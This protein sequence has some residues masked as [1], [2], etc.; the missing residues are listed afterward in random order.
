MAH[1]GVIRHPRFSRLERKHRLNHS[2][3]D[4]I[5]RDFLDTR[6]AQSD[7]GQWLGKRQTPIP[8][9]QSAGATVIA[10]AGDV[11]QPTLPN[12]AT[13]PTTAADT[14][15]PTTDVSTDATTTASTTTTDAQSTTSVL[16]TQTPTTTTTTSEPTSTTATSE[17]ST[18][19]ASTT[20]SSTSATTS[21]P[22]STNTLTS[23][24]PLP[25]TE[26][27]Q[28]SDA[29][30]STT[31]STTLSSSETST[32][33]PTTAT[34]IPT[35]ASETTSP[36]S[37][38]TSD[39]P[40]TTTYFGGDGWSGGG[41][42]SWTGAATGTAT[43]GIEQAP[44]ATGAASS[45]SGSSLDSETKGKIAG[46][47]VGGVAGLAM[48]IILAL[49]F[50]RRRRAALQQPRGLPSHDVAG[51]AAANEPPRTA[52]M[53]S[54]RSS[55]D[56]LFAASYFAPAFMKRW[57]Q[58][59]QTTRS[60]STLS[61]NPSERGFQKIAGRKIPSVLQ[62]G[63]DGY[64]DGSFGQ[65]SPTASE[66]SGGFPSSPPAP[67]RTSLSQPPPSH[68][69][70]MPLDTSYTREEEEAVIY[71]PSPARTPIAGSSNVS[72]STEPGISH[73]IP[74]PSSAFPAS[75]P[76]RPDLLG[77]SHPSFDGSRGS[78]FTESL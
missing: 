21:I 40:S 50:F 63:G 41:G 18:T 46:G 14:S 38:T 61:S 33:V 10:D 49:L 36:L 43:T 7:R 31:G 70:G 37:T 12:P 62:S 60:D 76:P 4:K 66:P 78:R 71:R 16:S 35:T 65:G 15:T 13:T 39:F 55:N 74:Q 11:P 69:Y 72:L 20:S 3:H 59:Q 22:S 32:S 52:E 56:P 24:E 45:G 26:T 47:V 64:G 17:S 23:T 67:P 51:T 68:P 28:S 19:A 2:H 25:A 44:S 5:N 8:Q 29:P 6:F 27:T 30:T 9:D 75:I 54:R 53:A 73:V 77:R 57:R 1:H 48:L 34:T 42:G 58:S